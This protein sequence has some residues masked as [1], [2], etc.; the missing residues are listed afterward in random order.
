MKL[1]ERLRVLVCDKIPQIIRD[2]G[3][4]PV[5][6]VAGP[7]EYPTRLRD[8]LTEEVAEFLD[9]GSDPGRA[10]RCSRSRLRAGR[11]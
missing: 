11:H 9:S 2:K 5:T 7:D 8:K 10:R 6:Y 3:P 4:E 1:P